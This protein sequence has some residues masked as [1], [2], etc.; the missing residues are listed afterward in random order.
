[1]IPWHNDLS[2]GISLAKQEF[3]VGE[4]IMLHI[5]AD[6]PGDAPA[7]VQG[8]GDMDFFEAY[9]LELFGADGHRIL[10]RSDTKLAE[11]CKTAQDVA[12]ACTMN[13]VVPIP[14]RTCEKM[15][16]V[17]L[18]YSFSK[19]LTNSYHLPPG[20]YTIRLRQSWG[21]GGGICEPHGQNSA[22]AAAGP[23]L[24]FSIKRP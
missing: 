6:N 21:D 19:A 10:S 2:L 20:K 18:N 11:Q 9:G 8:C 5:W 24:I 23:T 13:G 14:A 7:S 12:W 3:K 1:M 16:S 15:G 22:S 17:N 4:P